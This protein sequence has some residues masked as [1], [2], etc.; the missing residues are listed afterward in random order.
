MRELTK[1]RMLRGFTLIE[2]LV[3]IAIIAI[4]IALLL[5]AVQQAREAARRTQCRNNMKQL[6]LALHNYHDVFARLPVGSGMNPAPGYCQSLG[7]SG[8]N[9]PPWGGS[10]VW[11]SGDRLVKLLP[12]ID[13][14]PLYN[15]VD[16]A[17]DV[18][19]C[20]GA[21]NAPDAN[22]GGNT[23][24]Q[25][26]N[27]NMP[28]FLCPSDDGN[29]IHGSRSTSNYGWSIGSQNMPSRNGSCT[30]YPKFFPGDHGNTGHGNNNNA[31]L[32]SGVFGR[33]NWSSRIADIQD[34]TSN[35]IM[36]GEVR[37][38]CS[39]HH[40][41]GWWDGNRL[42]TATTGPINF[43][44]RC[45]GEAADLENP[46]DCNWHRNWQTSQA[47]RSRH[48]GGAFF[49][50]GDGSVQFLSENVDYATYQR[51]GGRHDGEVVGQF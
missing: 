31:R 20:Y 16:F 37:P 39:D 23:A 10:G 41:G 32:I 11:K 14:A 22:C 13:Q 51:L 27:I 46:E 33:L 1:K 44:I 38:A 17:N 2:L 29:S 28:A 34:G 26:L 36:M 45:R 43:P 4:L 30:A 48:E 18:E 50:L 3:V 5:P 8:N 15:Q 19:G 25:I 24:N 21:G 12:Y 49:L 7:G 40:W 47:F 42:W 9:C 35:T 6:G